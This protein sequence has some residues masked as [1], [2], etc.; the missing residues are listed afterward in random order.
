MGDQGYLRRYSGISDS[1]AR[2]LIDGGHGIQCNWWRNV[3][4]IS[5]PEIRD[6]VTYANLL[7]HVNKYSSADP[8]TGRP[9]FEGTPFISLTSGCVE[10]NT[11]LRTNRI[12]PARRTAL[13]FATRS[14]TGP[15]Y[16]FYCW[17]FVSLNPAVEVLGVAEEVRELNTYRSYSLYQTEGEITAK[18]HIP[19]NQIEKCEKYD[20]TKSRD[21]IPAWT[22]WNNEF[23]DP[24]TVSNVREL[25]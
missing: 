3:H 25:F 4:Q 1:E 24:S 13:E 19:S 15:G 16:L 18:I 14:G 10:R 11:A 9:F 6:K 20:P 8:V 17:V 7:R 12:V 2:I 22:H 5:P 21:L 23:E